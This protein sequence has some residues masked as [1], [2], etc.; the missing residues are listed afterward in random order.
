M[1]AVFN[2]PKLASEDPQPLLKLDVGIQPSTDSAFQQ[3]YT[4]RAHAEAQP[5]QTGKAAFNA[6]TWELGL[7]S[8]QFAAGQAVTIGNVLRFTQAGLNGGK[9]IVLNSV[10]S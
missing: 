4:Y 9:P 8:D 1:R 6:A 2:K 7:S 3:P 5:G 10:I